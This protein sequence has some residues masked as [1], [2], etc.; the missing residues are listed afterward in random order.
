MLSRDKRL[1]LDTWNTSGLHENV[2]GNQFSTFDLLQ[3]H[4]CATP[5]E[6]GSVPQAKRVGDISHKR[7]QT[8]S[9]HN[10]NAD[11]CMKAVDHEV[12]VSGVHSA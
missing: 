7:W 5:R 10:S 1:P 12:I 6:T 4:H 11:I 3:N 9:R 2:I 8:E